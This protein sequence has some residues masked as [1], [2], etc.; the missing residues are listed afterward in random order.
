[1]HVASF[2]P[3][4]CLYECSFSHLHSVPS[5]THSTLIFLACT[6]PL[7][8]SPP[9]VSLAP[10]PGCRSLIPLRAR[11]SWALL[12]IVFALYMY[13]IAMVLSSSLL[14]YFP[15][16]RS[17]RP[18]EGGQTVHEFELLSTLWQMRL[19]LASCHG[20]FGVLSLLSP[21]LTV[22]SCLQFAFYQLFLNPPF[23]D[24]SPPPVQSI[25]DTGLLRSCYS[26]DD[27]IYKPFTSWPSYSAISITNSTAPPNLHLTLPDK[28]HRP[29]YF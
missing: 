2:D 17:V 19:E 28:P 3:S 8:L 6:S 15:T 27:P 29:S 16:T 21:E 4:S 22:A 1:M 24:A 13:V 23:L 26:I 11:F 20:H 9:Y 18:K 25:A 7:V 12:M 5:P 10:S 14:L